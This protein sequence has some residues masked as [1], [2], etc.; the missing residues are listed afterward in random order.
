MKLIDALHDIGDR[1]KHAGRVMNE[2]KYDVIHI[3]LKKDEVIASHHAKEEALI[4]VRTG[5]VQF[6]VED[7][8][9]LLTNEQILQM[10]PYEKH[11]LK[12]LEETDLILLK[13]K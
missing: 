6:G 13:I 5:K 8:T 3:H 12:A 11:D 9:V 10:E 1:T 2:G 4:I 7:E